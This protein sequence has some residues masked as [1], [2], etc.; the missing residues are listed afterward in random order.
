MGTT[1]QNFAV[2]AG[3]TGVG[4]YNLAVPPF[5]GANATSQE[6]TGLPTDGSA[7]TIS[8]YAMQNNQWSV[9]DS[10][11]VTAANWISGVFPVSG[12]FVETNCQDPA[13]NGTSFITG[14]YTSSAQDGG[15]Y[16]GTLSIATVDGLALS[17]AGISATGTYTGT[18]TQTA[19]SGNYT[20]DGVSSGVLV[21]RNQGTFNASLTGNAIS[22]T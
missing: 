12:N 2:R 20:L 1:V 8:L 21:S 15:N 10:I 11:E 5:S 9:V 22:T 16:T 19:S 13:D 6:L 14:T 7:F 18:H 17:T 3:N 4:S